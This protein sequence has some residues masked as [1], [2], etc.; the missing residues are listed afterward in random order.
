[1]AALIKTKRP[2][3]VRPFRFEDDWFAG[4]GS[5]KTR[6]RQMNFPRIETSVRDGHFVAKADLPGIRSQDV[7]VSVEANH[8]TIKGERKTS[9]EVRRKNFR[10]S[11]LFYGSF[12]RSIPLPEGVK[13]E[14]LKA[15]YHDGVLEISAPYDSGRQPKKIDVEKTA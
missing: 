15:K 14:K 9:K 5:E 3:V 7:Q 4:F 11:E 12:E 2:E 10:R 13:T 6:M 1:M 8:L